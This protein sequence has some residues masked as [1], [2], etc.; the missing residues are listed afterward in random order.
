MYHQD[1]HSREPFKDK[2]NSKTKKKLITNNNTTTT[3]MSQSLNN[4]VYSKYLKHQ[5]NEQYN[6]DSEL[7]VVLKTRGDG[8]NQHEKATFTNDENVSFLSL[9]TKLFKRHQTELV[10]GDVYAI[11]IEKMGNYM[12]SDYI[13]AIMFLSIPA[14]KQKSLLEK[15]DNVEEEVVEYTIADSDDEEESEEVE[16]PKP[17]TKKP[18]TK[19]KPKRKPSPVSDEE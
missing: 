6:I 7:F 3:K 17:K 4:F 13:K 11:G 8:M 16:K 15:Y 2:R 5:H 10:V 19:R 12:S 9:K 18:K 1:Q 14:K